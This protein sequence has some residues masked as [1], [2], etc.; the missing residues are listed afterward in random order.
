MPHMGFLSWVKYE[1][2]SWL[3]QTFLCHCF[4]VGVPVALTHSHPHLIPLCGQGQYGWGSGHHPVWLSAANCPCGPDPALIFELTCQVLVTL[5]Q[6]G[7]SAQVEGAGS[8]FQTLVSE[9]TI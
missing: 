6:W 4:Q 2:D 9:S 3:G 5:G 7:P 1:S 8:I